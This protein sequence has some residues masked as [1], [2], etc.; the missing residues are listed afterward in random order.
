[1]RPE[2]L[3]LYERELTYIRQMA[4]EFAEQHPHVAARLGIEQD[5]CQDPHVERLIESFALLAARVHLKLEDEFPEITESLL[6]VLY[7]HYLAPVPSFSIAQFT[8]DPE[9]GRI[10]TGYEIQRHKKL[11]SRQ[12]QNTTCY[13]RTSY[14]VTLWPLD[15]RS[16]QVESGEFHLP[17]GGIA[18]AAITLRIGTQAGIDLSELELSSLRFFLKGEDQLVNQLYES[19]MGHLSG[20]ALRRPGAPQPS[21]FLLPDSL[22]E[23]GFGKDEGLLPYS[24]RSHIGYRLLL[25]YFCFPRKFLFFDVH[26]LEAV[27]GQG[28][29]EMFELMFLLER[30]LRESAGLDAST[31]R[32]GC[33]PI[34]NLFEGSAEPIHLDHAHTEYHVVADRSAQ[35]YIEVY[36]VDEVTAVSAATG[37]ESEYRPFYSLQHSLEGR[38]ATAFWHLTRRPSR[39]GKPGTE[40]YLSLVDQQ[41]NAATRTADK[42]A[43]R[44]TCTNRDL[45]PFLG[46][47]AELGIEGAPSVK[48]AMCITAPTAPTRPAAA[49]G[50]QWPLISHL[51]LNYLSVLDLDEQGAPDVL[52]AVLRLYDFSDA[53]ATRQQIE[54]QIAGLLSV[55][56]RQV[57]RRIGSGEMQGFARGVEVTLEFDESK[58]VSSGLY[59]FSSV[60]E[61]F[62]ALSV[63][64]NS[65]SETIAVSRQRGGVKRWPPRSG[66]QPL[67]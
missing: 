25:E 61:K 10:S 59:L 64:I 31:F 22:S 12:I 40:V 56:S 66:Y 62:L 23:V 38:R 13:F 63:S 49:R 53:P 42:L 4:S 44:V 51:S 17:N 45:P 1:M 20:V 19:L 29:G 3:A 54:Q 14:P 5:R 2:L 27:C 30:P 24:T 36:S 60:L 32:L 67:L 48:Q 18:T 39:P 21:V 7:P 6:Q 46:D 65:F 15:V 50:S 43:V 33:T 57:M 55:R 35:R 9:Q 52:R 28:F 34:V 11:F 41:L 16:A 8:L 37:E 26:R 58:Y 47:R